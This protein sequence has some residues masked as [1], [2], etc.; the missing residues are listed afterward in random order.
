MADVGYIAIVVAGFGAYWWRHL[1][2]ARARPRRMLRPLFSPDAEVALHVAAH[3]ASVRRQEVSSLHVLYG[4]L[5]DETTTQAIATAGGN[6]DAL[7][8]RVLAALERPYREP[9][10]TYPTDPVEDGQRLIG[11]A[12]S[13]ARYGNRLASCADLWAYLG[14]SCAAHLVDTAK[15]D[16]AAVLFALF[17]GGREPEVTLHGAGDVLVVLR[18]DHYTTQEFVCQMLRD[19]FALPNAQATAIM[20][21]THTEGRAVVGRFPIETARAKIGEVRA[22][23]HAQH[24]PLWIGVEPA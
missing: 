20:L 7:E 5:Q 16:R 11:R 18:N 24:F 9:A 23:S 8:D 15:L 22:L 14:D 10:G 12:A 13:M 21:A 2:H 1:R 19:V 17:H 6:P 3:E 4:L